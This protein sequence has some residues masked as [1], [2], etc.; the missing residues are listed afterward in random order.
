MV[1]GALKIN[2]FIKREEKDAEQDDEDEL[3][4]LPSSISFLISCASPFDN[5]SVAPFST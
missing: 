4:Q 3:L 1:D 5:R 2:S